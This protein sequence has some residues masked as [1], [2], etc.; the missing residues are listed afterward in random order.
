MRWHRMLGD[1]DALAARAA[2]T[3]ASP[4]QLVV[5]RAARPGG[6]DPPRPGPRAVP[7]AHVGL[8][9]PL[10]RRHRRAAPRLGV[11]VDWDRERSR[12]TRARRARCAPRSCSLYDKGLIYSGHAD[13]QLVPAL[14]DRALRPGGRARGGRR[15]ALAYVRYPLVRS[16]ARARPSTSRLPRPGPRRSWPTPAIAVHPGRPA[17]PALVGRTASCRVD[18]RE[19]RSWPTTAV[20][21]EFGT[22]AVKV[23]PGPRPDRLRDRPAPHLP[24]IMV[25]NLDGTMNE[26]AGRL[27]GHADAARP[28]S[29]LWRS[30]SEAGSSSRRSSR[31]ATRSATATAAGRWSSRWSPSSGTCASQPLADAGARGRARRPDPDRPRA[32]RQ[33][34]LQLDGEHPRLVHLAPALVGPPHPGLVLRRLRRR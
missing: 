16:S 17:L 18:R 21:Q 28:A 27:R 11:S 14:R 10:R 13:H 26:Q 5:E 25:M 6:Q 7:R 1:A 19:S 4:A 2:T 20:E 23:T 32:L 22:G 33:G 34:L 3:R 8:D 9:A 24:I 15:A 12:W 31:I 29:A 30:S